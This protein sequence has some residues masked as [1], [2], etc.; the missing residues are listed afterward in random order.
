M[1]S[2]FRNLLLVSSFLTAILN[3]SLESKETP[4][5]MDISLIQKPETIKVLLG[6]GTKSFFLDVTG[7]YRIYNP[8]NHA[9]I[10]EG[11]SSK[12]CVLEL[13]PNGLVWDE[14]YPQVFQVRI[15]PVDRHSSLVINGVQYKGCLEVYEVGGTLA[16]VNEIDVET[17]LKSTLKIKETDLHPEVLRALAITL[18]TDLYHDIESNK[19]SSWHAHARE[20]GYAGYALSFQ[21]LA[22]EKALDDTRHVIMVL[23]GQP[24]ATAWSYD[25]AGKTA[26]YTSIFRKNSNSPDG[27][28]F[29]A[30]LKDKAKRKWMFSLSRSELTQLL[31][32]ADISNID[33]FLDKG[34]EKV[35]GVKVSYANTFKTL[36]FFSFQQLM[37]KNRLKSNDF[38]VKEEKGHFIFEGFGE[39]PGVGLCLYSAEMLAKKGKTAP[40]ILGVFFPKAKLTSFG[41]H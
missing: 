19:K 21:N 27:I 30:A 26:S 25:S 9:L 28:V 13:T 16:I 33:L 8:I 31:K 40:E 7:S 11:R 3:P 34:T 23:D 14:A 35:Y 2:C 41:T 39:G 22:L 29:P 10:S 32:I 1:F 4:L 18:R 37:G 17:Y 6:Q 38:K 24:F 36:D 5:P 20:S 12:A 15:V